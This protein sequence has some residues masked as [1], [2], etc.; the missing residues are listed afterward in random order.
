M[1]E[2]PAEI[3]ELTINDGHDAQEKEK[4]EDNSL[5]LER[6]D[7]L[8]QKTLKKRG[9]LRVKEDGQTTYKRTS[10]SAI[11]AAIQLGIGYSVGRL[12]AK[13][14]RDILMQDFSFVEKVWFPCA[15]SRE[16]PSHR[17][18]DF[19]FKSYAPSAFRYF[20]DLF[21]MQPSDFLM[22]LSNEEL[23]ELGNPGASGSLF[24]LS[25]DDNFIIKTVQHKE[26]TFLQQLLPGYYMN[27]HQNPRTLLPKFFGLYCYQS[28]NVNIRLVVMNNILP[29]T[30]RCHQ[31]YDLKGSTFKRKASKSELAK[32]TPTKKDLDFRTDYSE[33]IIL[34]A[35]THDLVMK[36]IKRDC[37]VL[38]SFKIMDYSLLLG[39]HNMDQAMR[40]N[41]NLSPSNDAQEEENP[42][43][44]ARRAEFGAALEAIQIDKV[45]GRP[46]GG[47][48]AKSPKGDRLILFLGII[49][50][51]QSYRMA[52]K[53]EH[54]W[55]SLIHD[56][57]SVSV[58]NP[59]F[60][61]RRFINFMGEKVLKRGSPG[62]RGST[63]RRSV[64]RQAPNTAS[65]GSS[66]RNRAGTNE[67]ISER[68]NEP[69]VITEPDD[70]MVPPPYEEPSPEHEADIAEASTS[71]EEETVEEH[72]VALIVDKDV[73]T[74]PAKKPEDPI[75]ENE[76]PSVLKA[77]STEDN[78]LEVSTLSKT[79]VVESS[80]NDVTHSPA[81]VTS[82][83]QVNDS[84]VLTGN[85]VT[86]VKKTSTT[87]YEHVVA[88]NEIDDSSSSSQDPGILAANHVGYMKQEL[89][90]NESTSVVD[91]RSISLEI[92]EM[93]GIDL[94]IQKETDSPDSQFQESKVQESKVQQFKAQESKLRESK[95]QESIDDIL[96]SSVQEIKG[97]DSESKVSEPTGDS[98]LSNNEHSEVNNQILDPKI[99]NSDVQDVL[100]VT[101]LD[102]VLSCSGDIPSVEVEPANGSNLNDSSGSS[103]VMVTLL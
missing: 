84:L 1:A 87:T 55:K 61:A 32:K 74:S 6:K 54:G 91:A 76:S 23:R 39:I 90:N 67:P 40:E 42:E 37:R 58:H 59:S 34:E 30:F 72:T 65:F 20:R 101:N 9:H 18:N 95:V 2:K 44:V 31:I 43:R 75:I 13:Q 28:Q 25:A 88:T 89:V 36:T 19:K 15:G 103:D 47:I 4:L 27:L 35:E 53:L 96:D 41:E 38:E 16:T 5:S 26:A 17:F 11:M 50:I 48:P 51:L 14:E 33:G 45:E 7:S 97:D 22:A 100:Q 94:S 56:G 3:S 10:S 98:T 66:N 57:D 83:E 85:T 81:I 71:Q 92:K 69:T 60:Y 49:D 63:K 46:L 82:S 80:N 86:I 73:V 8:K 12:T 52:K 24:F 99:E 77:F 21:G 64:N 70:Q 29:T 62:A 78:P 79:V 93:N 102:T 68:A